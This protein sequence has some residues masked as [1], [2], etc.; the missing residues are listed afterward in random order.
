[1]SNYFVI[2]NPINHSLSPL[3]HNYWF[4]KYN[5]ESNYEKKQ[6]NESDLKDFVKE[7]R[8]NKFINGLNITVP[9][10]K[11]IIP[12]L[13]ELTNIS[14]KTL[15]VNTVYKKNGKLVGHNTD[16]EAFEQTLFDLKNWKEKFD[17]PLRS[18][19]IGAGGV[20]SSIIFAMERLD[21]ENETCYIMNR[22]KKNA[23]NLISN[24]LQNFYLKPK[25]LDWGNIPKNLDIIVNTTSVGL[26]EDE[27]LDLDFSSYKGFKNTLFYDLIYNPKETKFL[28]DAKKRGNKFMNGKMMFILQAKKSFLNWTKIDAEIDDEILKFLDK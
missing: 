4:K 19:I 22:T 18:L 20:T 7:M 26:K 14:Q 16:A 1:M 3:I 25:T 12:F 15:S 5:I 11:K 24:G 2:G 28:K 10:K 23:E 9:F 17:E 21:S 8:V 6:L 27:N 13:D